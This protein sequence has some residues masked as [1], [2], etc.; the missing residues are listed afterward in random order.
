MDDEV[1]PVLPP[2]GRVDRRHR[3]PGLQYGHPQHRKLDPVGKHHGHDFAGP[4]APVDQDPGQPI[5]PGVE[6]AERNH[7]IAQLAGDGLTVAPARGGR[8]QQAW[9]G[10][11]L[12]H[13]VVLW[14]ARASL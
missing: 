11:G 13:G 2:V 6:F 5:A 8:S 12:V 9:Q 4:D 7:A 10:K 1:V 14:K 3:R